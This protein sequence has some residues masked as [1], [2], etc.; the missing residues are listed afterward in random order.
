MS[1]IILNAEFK[2]TELDKIKTR[3][4]SALQTAKNEPD[5]MLRNVSAVV[6]FGADHP[7]GS[8]PTEESVKN[9][10]LKK[11]E[12]YYKTYFRPNVAYMAVVGDITLEEVKPLITK[13]FG[14]WVKSNVPVAQYTS[15]QKPKNTRV[16][17]V[18]RD[19]AVQ[20]VINVTYPVDLKPGS[21][22]A[23]KS[24]VANTIL[25]GGSQGRLFLNLREKHGWTYGSY[26][27]LKFDDL[28]G[29]FTAYSKGRNPVTDSSV[30]AILEEMKS[31]RTESVSQEQ[32]QNTINYLSGGFA[33]GL[34][35]PARVA[36]YAINIERYQ[37]PKDYYTNYLKN[38]ASVTRE[39]V[40]L[41]A[42]KYFFPN[43]ANI[44]VVGNKAEVAEKL[45]RFDSDGKIEM[46]DNY[47]K[48]IKQSSAPA[49]AIKM[50]FEELWNNYIQAI[51]G[52]QAI[53]NIKDIKIISTGA[54]QG[55]EVTITEMKKMPFKIKQNIQLKGM[56]LQ[57]VVFNG[58]KGF[59]LAQGNKTELAGDELAEIKE[60]ADIQAELHPGQYNISRIL[61][62][63]EEVNGNPVYLVE[64]TDSKGKKSSEYYDAKTALL[65]KT[66]KGEGMV[67][68]Y[69]DYREIP[70][71]GG[72]KFPYEVKIPIGPGAFID[73]K[74]KSVEIN[75]NIA[76]AEFE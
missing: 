54:V 27:S 17:F 62:S 5:A 57:E 66:I 9:I 25:G 32:L 23:I 63:V 4:I 10:S 38:L 56:T 41:M 59:Q 21:P 67:T 2:Q 76:D 69:S 71:S 22:D 46:R 37:I 68:E 58:V 64:V 74:V 12:D 6:N 14:K 53:K 19:G 42:A 44:V 50:S 29:S 73:A 35:D 49:G 48:E 47:G 30:A 55:M 18:P 26:S 52:E 3:T 51:G 60:Q 1:D 33:I 13:Y 72:Y 31:L 8:I 15:P 20:G 11:V 61:K 45:A 43:Q 28:M 40:K 39:D 16:I 75:S 65:V 70:N 24:S 34:E 7:Y 36:Q